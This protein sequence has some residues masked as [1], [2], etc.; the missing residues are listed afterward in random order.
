MNSAPARLPC[1]ARPRIKVPLTNSSNAMPS[2]A[3]R[4]FG[5]RLLLVQYRR[6][7]SPRGRFLLPADEETDPGH[8][9][10]AE[11]HQRRGRDLQLGAVNET[12]EGEDRPGQRVA[13]RPA[14]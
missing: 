4:L 7:A 10:V 9:D 3:A 6:R 12:E 2:S 8:E 5:R 13:R 1:S 11:R 14:E